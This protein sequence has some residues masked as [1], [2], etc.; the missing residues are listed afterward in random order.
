M[1]EESGLWPP[2]TVIPN[3]LPNVAWFPAIP[4]INVPGDYMGVYAKDPISWIKQETFFFKVRCL[5]S[6]A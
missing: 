3:G 1:T 4:G 2:N 6:I 5:K